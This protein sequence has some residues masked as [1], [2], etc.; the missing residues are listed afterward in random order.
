MNFS[1]AAA[2]EAIMMATFRKNGSSETSYC[3]RVIGSAYYTTAI[4]RVTQQLIVPLDASQIFELKWETVSG[5]PAS[6]ALTVNMIGYI[7]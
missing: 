7:V 4:C 1:A 3:P 6:Y 2:G 5:T